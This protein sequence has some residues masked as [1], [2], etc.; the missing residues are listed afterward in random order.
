MNNKIDDY[1]FKYFGTMNDALQSLPWGNGDIGANLWLS[2]DGNIHLLI[3]KTDSW[4]ELY[5][6]LKPAHIV[7]SMKPCPFINGANFELSVAEGTLN[8][9]VEDTSLLAYVDAFAPCVRLSLK[10]NHPVDTYLKL[11]NYRCEPIDPKDDFSNYFSQGGKHGIVES[12]DIITTTAL[13][14]VAQIH[15]N[16]DSCYEY[17]LKN[18]DMKTYIGREKDP[19]LGLTFGA[20]LYS[21]NMTAEKDG[22][23]AK[24]IIQMDASVFV[25]TRFT[26]SPTEL[27]DSFDSLYEQYGVAD[28]KS[29]ADH[30]RSWREFWNRAYIYAEG[31][32]FAE[33]ITRAFVY[34][35][36]MTRCSDRGNAPI[37]FN[38]SLFTA[39]QMEDRPENYDARRWG[40]PYWFQNTRI[41]YWYL[42]LMGDYE[43]MLPMFDMY[44]NMLP[45]SRERCEI[46]FGHEGIMIPETVS[47]FGLYANSNY[48]I[49]D[50]HGVRRGNGGRVLR[51]GEPCNYYIKYHYNGMLELSYMMLKYLEKSEDTS[52]REL[53]LE[54]IEQTLLFF[55]CHFDRVDEK[56]I[57]NPVSALETWQVCANDAPDI[58]GLLAVCEKLNAM[59]NVPENM[60][61]LVDS[62]MPAIPDL[63]TEESEDGTV[64]APCEFKILSEAKNSE[65]PELY[66]V[67]PF[68]RFGLGKDGLELSRRTYAKRANRHP[69][70]WSQD[71]VDAALLGLKD[72]AVAHL[73]RQSGMKDKRALFPAFWGPNFDETPDQDHGGMT[74][75]GLIFTLLQTSEHG[76]TAFPAWPQKWNVRFRLPLNKNRFIYGEQINGQRTVREES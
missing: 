17:S 67:F 62:I 56:M 60:K 63:P 57:I 4:S 13:G 20:G 31:D 36:Y 55:D 51:R 35:R 46:Y 50:S 54:F 8:I 5:R 30:I 23:S 12:A 45:I 74:S 7:I 40:A 2:P 19:L 34:Q 9:S 58:A 18:Q 16:E 41:P 21:P 53:M 49:G 15:R 61:K 29:C 75:L 3:S 76:Y 26:Q 24:A 43:S 71:P 59:P 32:E 38:G 47:H 66:S 39:D 68:E 1:S 6:L 11:A 14:G 48:G 25:E 28:Q 70:G 33:Q 42:L 65:N 69:G 72:E 52:R 10:S 22:L 64:L 73:I 37:K 27:A 44:L